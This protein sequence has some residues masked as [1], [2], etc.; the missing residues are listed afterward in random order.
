MKY[1]L[2]AASGEQDCRDAE[3]YA[4]GKSRQTGAP[5][6]ILH[7]I[8]NELSHYGEVDPLAT[9][10]DRR[11]F[12]AY[13]DAL[14]VREARER[15]AD[16]LAEADEYGITAELIIESGRLEESLK[17]RENRAQLVI[18][19]GRKPLFFQET[20]RYRRLSRKLKC[21]IRHVP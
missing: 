8:E 18:L 15:F 17:A 7:V 12:L 11:D 16:L 6:V 9:E 3:I 14:A 19:G 2:L 4:L 20:A 5:L 1:I 13:V 21:P 10:G